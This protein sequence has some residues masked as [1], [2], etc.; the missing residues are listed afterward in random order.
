MFRAILKAPV[1]EEKK[2]KY[3][4]L[5]FYL[6]PEMIENI[7]GEK[8]ESYLNENFYKPLEAKTLTFNPLNK[9]PIHQIIPTEL[10]TFFRMQQIHG[11][12]HDEGAA[13][14]GGV[15]SNAGLFGSA[16]D[17]AKLMQMYLNGGEYNGIRFIDSFS[18]REFTRYQ[19][20]ENNNRRGLGFDKPLLEYDEQKSSVARDA[21]PQSYGHSGYTGTMVWV[22]PKEDLIFIFLSNRVYPTRNNRKLYEMN[23]RPKIHQVIYDA[24]KN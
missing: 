4:G 11:T 3:S 17:L 6:F 2:Y 7:S 21:S 15:S 20:P 19:F 10:D 24:I 5:A 14:M 9:F 18:I 12:V 1:S 16:E 22:D 13:M 23:I 8:Y